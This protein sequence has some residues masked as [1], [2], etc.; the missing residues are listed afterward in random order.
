MLQ[1]T[2]P[3]RSYRHHDRK[4]ASV[5]SN[6]STPR[7]GVTFDTESGKLIDFGKRQITVY[8]GW[9]DIR[10]WRKTPKRSWRHIR[11]RITVPAGDRGPEI[12]NLLTLDSGQLVF[13]FGVDP[14]A[15]SALSWCRWFNTIPRP[16]RTAVSPFRTR[17]WHLLSFVAR[18]GPGAFDLVL[19]N[20][21]NAFMLAS[22]WVFHSPPVRQP[23]RS[24]RALLQRNQTEI[25]RW[26]GFPATSAVR[27]MLRRIAPKSLQVDTLL[28]LRDALAGDRAKAVGKRLAHLPRVN[29][30]VLRIVT[31]PALFPFAS[32]SLLFEIAAD[33]TQDRQPTT[34]WE[35]SDV[36][37]MLQLT[38]PGKPVP[39]IRS[40]KR[41]SE[42]HE[43]LVREIDA[44]GGLA[45]LDVQFPSP[46]LPGTAQI[47]PVTDMTG[48]MKE[49]RQQRSC[50][51]S[52][53]HDIL[54]GR[55]YIYRVLPERVTVSLIRK[56]NGWGLGE[57]ASTCNREPSSQ[58][59]RQVLAWFR[60]ANRS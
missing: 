26:L 58:S 9:P 35:L 55:V 1:A 37:R 41:L 28:Y 6:W 18:C 44:V 7:P 15:R 60:L 51:A 32:P 29:S 49:A 23:M 4:G 52:Y 46:P 39:A 53:V 12:R 33:E 11:P 22:S 43:A 3:G 45:N 30:G 25:Q 36:A 19:T 42:L 2:T 59:R 13:D 48:L 54:R 38:R 24:A 50:V 20:P 47:L 27:T 31:D 16:V 21:A 40:C 14:F 5:N 57:M 56:R 10:A 8:R 17:H 34:A